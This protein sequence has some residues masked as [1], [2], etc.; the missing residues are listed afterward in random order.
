M[1]HTDHLPPLPNEEWPGELHHILDDMHGRPLNV[2]KLMANHPKLLMA[3]WNYRN[4]SVTGGDLSQRQCELVILR[5]AHHTG[6]MYEWA[7]HVDRGLKAGLSFEEI[8]RV[9]TG[10]AAPGWPREDA[11]LLTAVDDCT[12]ENRINGSTLGEL[13]QFYS[14]RQVLDIIA[15]QGMYTTLGAMINTWGLELDDFITPPEEL[16]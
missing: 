2:H 12:R 1:K 10:P 11:L 15:I 5:T 3:W 16:L 13:A 9:R 4:Y 14:A 8:D 6:A 7:S